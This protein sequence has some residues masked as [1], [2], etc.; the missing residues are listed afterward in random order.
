M[1]NT[2]PENKNETLIREK[3]SKPSMYEVILINDDYTPMEFVVD[4]LVRYFSKT[5][6]QAN[7]IMIHVHQ[8]GSGLCG[9]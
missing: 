4:V 6:E 5:N 9:T 8:N 1:T 7:E 3:L 2:N